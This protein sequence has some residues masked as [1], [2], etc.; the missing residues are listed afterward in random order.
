ML[1]LQAILP[2]VRTLLFDTFYL[3]FRSSKT[4]WKHWFQFIRFKFCF[5]FLESLRFSAN[6]SVFL[7][8]TI[9]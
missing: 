3:K 8:V 2:F 5:P 6:I 9:D 7:C 1:R 4:T